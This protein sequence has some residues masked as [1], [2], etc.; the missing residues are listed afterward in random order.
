MM[1]VLVLTVIL[2]LTAVSPVAADNLSIGVKI[3]LPAPPPI[4][5]VP[6]PPVVVTRPPSS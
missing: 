5:V 3:G 2:A 6:P 1:R 4:V